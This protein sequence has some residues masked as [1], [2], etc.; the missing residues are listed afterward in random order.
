MLRHTQKRN[1]FIILLIATLLIISILF[2][3]SPSQKTPKVTE[4]SW[5][6][7]AYT[8]KQN[9]YQ[10]SVMLYGEITSPYHTTIEAAITADVKATPVLDGDR[11]KHNEVLVKLDDREAKIVY[12]RNASIAKQIE[13]EINIE[14]QQY[15]SDKNIYEHE[16][17]LFEINKRDLERLKKLGQKNYASKSEI[18]NKTIELK[19]NAIDLRKFEFSVQ[20]HEHQ[21]ALLRAKLSEAKANL[22]Q[23]ELDL[24]RTEIRAPF[25]G[26]ITKL[27]VAVGN[28]VN[29]GEPIITLYD[30]AKIEIS[31]EIPEKYVS[32]I[33]SA[34]EKK[35]KIVA[36]LVKDNYPMK[37]NLNRLSSQVIEGHSGLNAFFKPFDN[38]YVLPF[39]LNVKFTMYLPVQR[40]TYLIPFA[41]LYGKNTIYKIV[42][43]H[44]ERIP[45]ENFGNYTDK[46]Q[47]T[48]IIIKSDHLK[49][50]DEILSTHL[51]NAIHGLSVTIVKD[52]N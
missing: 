40:K 6:V 17:E 10:P 46:N 48:F 22:D 23:S 28:R 36:E 9:S 29:I 16:E 47:K 42:D 14:I 24:S 38:T 37:F 13:N 35:Q 50:G 30:P 20:K 26:I 25:D 5:R 4:K 41:S 27:H 33:T 49:T 19:K 44:L 12:Q 32:I 45:V 3:T 52:T 15:E 8:I 31:A 18:D 21:I 2:I 51:P 43:N 39:G 1:A 11:V 7:S 34:F